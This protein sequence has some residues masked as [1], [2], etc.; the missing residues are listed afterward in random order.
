MGSNMDYDFSTDGDMEGNAEVYIPTTRAGY[1][2]ISVMGNAPLDDEQEIT[3]EANILP[4]EIRSVET[5]VAGNTGKVTVKLIGSKFRYDM[6][7]RLFMGNP[8][9]STMTNIIEAEELHYINF[10][11]VCVTFDLAG[12]KEG[13]YS[14][15]AFN[16]CAGYTYLMNSFMVVAGLPEN[17]STNLIIPEGLRQNRYCILTLEYGNIGN[18]DIVDPKIKLVS[19]GGSWIGL[20]RGEINVHRTELDIPIGMEGEP[21]GILR[22]GVRYTVSIYCFTNQSLEFV[23][24]SNE[25]IYHYEQL[26]DEVIK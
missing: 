6:P 17:L 26:R 23:I 10:N 18:T 14:I 25:D 20:E 19:L 16:Y 4:F 9:D 7:V 12:A 24:Y 13:V 22:P 21:E 15:E 8:A 3:I 5:N 11:E 2:G 1:Y